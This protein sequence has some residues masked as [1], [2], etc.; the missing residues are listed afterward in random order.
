V[1]MNAAAAAAAVRAPNAAAIRKSFTTQTGSRPHTRSSCGWAQMGYLLASGGGAARGRSPW[2]GPAIQSTNPTH[3][4]GVR[5][6]RELGSDC[7]AG[8]T[9]GQTLSG[10]AQLPGRHARHGVGQNRRGCC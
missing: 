6:A 9:A 10:L 3:S 5:H 2:L 8:N 7:R 4:A 1:P